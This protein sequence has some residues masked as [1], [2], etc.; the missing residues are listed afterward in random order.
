MGQLN[1]DFVENIVKRGDKGQHSPLTVWEQ[2][3]LAYA[4]LSLH[5]H[6]T[7]PGMPTLPSPLERR[8]EQK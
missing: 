7:W 6:M 5:G 2:Q 4:W 1:K 3:Q 8:S